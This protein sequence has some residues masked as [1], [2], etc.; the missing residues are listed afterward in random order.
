MVWLKKHT[1]ILDW[2][3][4]RLSER[5]FFILSSILIGLT[6]GLGA[7]VLKTLVHKI[8]EILTKDYN[9][10]FQYYLYLIFP[11]LGLLLSVFYI[12][13]F[14]K[15]EMEKGT[16][17]VLYSIDRKSSL[18]APFHMFGHIITSAITIGFGGS[19]GLEAPIATTGSAIGSNYARTYHLNYNVPRKF[20]RG[21]PA[22]AIDERR[23]R[24]GA[25]RAGALHFGTRLRRLQP[26]PRSLRRLLVGAADL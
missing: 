17:F 12:K 16:A 10:P 8:H 7:I 1:L 24:A 6:A 19:S 9:L 25:G 4:K 2:A 5:Q 20:R 14:H 3:Q 22:A 26:Q 21:M 13:R 15:G 11:L 23:S 18:L